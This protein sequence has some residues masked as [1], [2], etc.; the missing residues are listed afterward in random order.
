MMMK[1]SL[2]KKLKKVMIHQGKGSIKCTIIYMP[3]SCRGKRLTIATM[4]DEI[5]ILERYLTCLMAVLYCNNSLHHHNLCLL[6]HFQQICC[7]NCRVF[8]C[9]CWCHD[10]P[11]NQLECI[12]IVFKRLCV[13]PDDLRMGV[14]RFRDNRLSIGVN[15]LG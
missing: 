13:V 11:L 14:V 5:Y 10:A 6:C 8:P 15:K 7:W 1:R 12:H 2:L 9:C 3:S 4:G